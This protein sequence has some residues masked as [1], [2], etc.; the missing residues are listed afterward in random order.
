MAITVLL[1]ENLYSA[2]LRALLEP[3]LPPG[4]VIRRPEDGME[5]LQNRRLLFAVALDPS[6]CN[7]AY[8]GMLRALRG[9][10]TL[11]RGS[12]A[13]VIVT[14]VG[15]FY[16]KD[17]ARDMVFA[18][19]QAGCAFL[20]RPLVEATGSLRNFRTQA[21]IGGTDEVTAFHAAAAE[22][23][24]RLD[25]WEKPAPVQHVLALHA[26][27]RAT[28]NTLALWELVKAGLPS[29]LGVQEIC[30]RNG[31]MADCNGC[32]Y[33]ACL[34]FGEQGGCFYGGPMVDEVYPAV[35]KC[36]A[37]VMLCANYNDALA[38]NLTAC[39]NRLTALFRQTRMYDKRLFGLIV[40]GYSGGDLLARQLISALNMNKSFY[41]PPRFSLLET[42]NERGSLVKLPGIEA[43]A[44][45]FAR[46][47]AE[48]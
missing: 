34:H 1:P 5:D 36:D 24:G 33:T 16:T 15:E 20:G 3:L 25:G 17:V 19:N 43:Q 39:V 6:G 27:Q 42:A 10:D 44:A 18:A 13:G 29:D 48:S 40:S 31:T 14:G 22:L 21:Q 2:P 38:A 30:L 28:S 37:L 4:S 35:R 46:H 26:S 12:V 9:S 47:I 45:A 11:L 23:I 41:L 7:L 8:Y 32:S